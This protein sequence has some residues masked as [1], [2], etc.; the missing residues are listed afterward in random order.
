MPHARIIRADVLSTPVDVGKFDLVTLFRFLLR[1][2]KLREPVLRWLRGVVK[3]DGTL[4]VNN[5]RNAYSLR[6]VAY[7]AA[8]TVKP[9][10]FEGDLLTDRQ[11]EALLD[12]FYGFEI[13]ERYSF[14]VVPSFKGRLLL[15]P[16]VVLAFERLTRSN[17]S[18][19][20]LAKNRIYVCHP[21]SPRPR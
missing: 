12:R 3:D 11:M 15:P 2:G 16:S 9:N 17:R 14:G 18:L 8:T 1:A 4:I 7:K 5:H 20:G 6:G 13:A 10:G 19:S 21:R